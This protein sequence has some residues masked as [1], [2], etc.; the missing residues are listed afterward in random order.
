[1]QLELGTILFRFVYDCLTCLFVLALY[2][3]SQKSEEDIESP[4]TGATDEC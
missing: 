2:V 4:G 1:M 3:H